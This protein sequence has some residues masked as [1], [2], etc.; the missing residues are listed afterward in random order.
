MKTK[1]FLILILFLVLP[2]TLAELKVERLK[3]YVNNERQTILEDITGSEDGG[4]IENVN[5]EDIIEFDLRFINTWN[6]TAKNIEIR[7]VIEEI[8]SGND[9]SVEV[10]DFNLD[11]NKEINKKLTFT[12]PSNVRK[13]E[14][15]AYLEITAEYDNHSDPDF[16]IDFQVEIIEGV[17]SSSNSVINIVSDLTNTTKLYLEK[18]DRLPEIEQ[19]KSTKAGFESELTTCKA[20]LGICDGEKNNYANN[21][22]QKSECEAKVKEAENKDSW[23]LPAA[24]IGLIYWFGIRKKKDEEKKAVDDQADDKRFRDF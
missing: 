9:L 15:I 17:S 12:I 20:S 21:Y 2:V 6:D 1:L 16:Q 19:C 23:L 22:I 14:Y 3:V 24:V 8:N 7:G 4:L 5:S 10:D 11:Y 13:D 18:L